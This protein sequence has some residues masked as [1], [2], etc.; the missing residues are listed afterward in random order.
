[1]PCLGQT[2]SQDLVNN[3]RELGRRNKK[4][5]D[6]FYGRQSKANGSIKVETI[7]RTKNELSR[8]EVRT[9]NSFATQETVGEVKS[10]ICNWCS[11]KFKVE[12]KAMT[13]LGS[14]VDYW[15]GGAHYCNERDK[16]E[17]SRGVP[18]LDFSAFDPAKYCSKKC[19]CDAYNNR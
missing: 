5:V 9:G 11:R 10:V 18:A 3:A 14:T 16:K 4:T 7:G 1:M 6:R 15:D 13:V 12:K 17:Q 2:S 19:A 8:K